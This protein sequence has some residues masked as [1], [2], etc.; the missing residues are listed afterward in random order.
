MRHFSLLTE[1]AARRSIRPGTDNPPHPAKQV[2]VVAVGAG[3]LP[4]A[5]KEL[6]ARPV[7]M[8]VH[9]SGG[10]HSHQ[11]ATLLAPRS[12]ARRRFTP[13]CPKAHLYPSRDG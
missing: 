12:E 13:P 7:A 4:A 6:W 1:G 3:V 5:S 9:S 10:V 2:A 8:R 11:A